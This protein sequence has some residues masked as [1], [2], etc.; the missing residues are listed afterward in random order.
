MHEALSVGRSLLE[1]ALL[2]GVGLPLLTLTA[3]RPAAGCAVLALLVPLT[4]GIGRGTV[5]PVLRPSEALAIVVLTGLLYNIAARRRR[6]VFV[7][8]DLVILIFVLVE[9]LIPL[10]TILLR[11]GHVDSD[12]WLTVL[13]PIQYLAVYMLFSRCE[14]DAASL[15]WIIN[16]AFVAS[17]VVAAIAVL[18]VLSPSFHAIVSTY[19]EES[20][21]PSWDPV[22]RPS[23]LVTHYSAVAGFGLLNGSLATAL[24]V[25]RHP[26][27]RAPWLGLVIVANVGGLLVSQTWAPLVALPIL[28]GAI[29]L[30]AGRIPWRQLVMA[31]GLVA[32]CVVAF[33]PLASERIDQQQIFSS[34]GG[35]ALPQSLDT[36]FRYWQEFFIPAALD[37][38]WVGSAASAVDGD[39]PAPSS[40]P[41]RLSMFID[42]EYLY[43]VLR[44]GVFA[45][46]MLLVLFAALGRAGWR[47]RASPDPSARTLGAAC[48]AAVLALAITGV[49]SEYLTFSALTQLFWML[50]GL[51]VAVRPEAPV[52]GDEIDAMWSE[53]SLARLREAPA[54]AA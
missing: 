20:P 31:A 53:P 2:S 38:L 51:L 35:L 23:S 27:F 13:A 21:T 41:E 22:Y 1:V 54:G 37:N 40:V 44:A 47:A 45:L 34:S 30:C 32:V 16:L 29:V 18:E 11:P 6:L 17:V 25:G 14:P 19:Y 33:L 42:N 52:A 12:T 43:E 4:G 3:W 24:L 26:G 36:R 46:L 28:V 8:L 15:R 48:L 10:L 9:V 50:V 39:Y 5:V 7:G 49:T